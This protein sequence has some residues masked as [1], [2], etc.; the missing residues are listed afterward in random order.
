MSFV[1]TSRDCVVL[2]HGPVIVDALGASEQ[3][4]S[5]LAD[6]CT[7]LRFR[8]GSAI[9]SIRIADW[10]DSLGRDG[11]HSPAI[12]F[13]GHSF[14]PYDMT[15]PEQAEF[16]ERGD[17]RRRATRDMIAKYIDSG[18]ID[19]LEASASTRTTDSFMLAWELMDT[20]DHVFDPA[21]WRL[22]SPLTDAGEQDPGVPPQ[23]VPELSSVMLKMSEGSREW[24]R[25]EPRT[26]KSERVQ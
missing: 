16:A 25:G 20:F 26:A 13:N 17:E 11:M 7:R 6:V 3:L 1:D 8:I 18:A 14:P 21:Y 23:Q 5:V 2:Q 22:I 12:E 15:E 19:L 10:Y 9:N 4:F 24:C